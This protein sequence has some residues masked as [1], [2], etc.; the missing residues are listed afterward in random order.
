M[1]TMLDAVER[2]HARGYLLDLAAVPGARLRCGACGGT[3]DAADVT[4]EETVRFEG[5]SNPDDEAILLAIATPCGHRG[6]FSAAFGPDTPAEESQV[7][8]ALALR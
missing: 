4:V 1:E 2:L 5:D 8:Q 7:L 6:L 3:T